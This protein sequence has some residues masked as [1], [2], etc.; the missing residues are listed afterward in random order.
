MMARVA[1]DIKER[2]PLHASATSSA[3]AGNWIVLPSATPERPLAATY[4]RD[5]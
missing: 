2:I 3:I 1:S 5:L 4:G